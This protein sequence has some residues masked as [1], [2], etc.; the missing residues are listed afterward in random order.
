MSRKTVSQWFS[1]NQDY[2][3]DWGKLLRKILG[4]GQ[5]EIFNADQG[6]QFSD[7]AFTFAPES[8][9]IRLCSLLL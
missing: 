7:A 2:L 3:P 1:E 8:A 5:P 6:V 4:Q 9:G